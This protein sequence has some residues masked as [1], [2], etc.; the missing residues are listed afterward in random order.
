M[1]QSTE[2]RFW[3]KVN[4]TDSCWL[5]TAYRN[6]KGYG[7]FGMGGHRG[8]MY[9]AH[10][11]SWE[12]ANGTIP[13]G[14]YVCHACDV[15][16]CVNP[17]H[18]WLGTATDNNRDMFAKGRAVSYCGTKTHCTNGHPFDSENTRKRPGGKRACAVCRSEAAKRYWAKRP[19]L[20]AE[21]SRQWR[22]A[23]KEVASQSMHAHT[24]TH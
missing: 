16:A 20:R 9:L 1:R 7:E 13:D 12:M 24:L 6:R 11:V 17:S 2:Q 4:K 15:P 22:Q 3:A 21:R 23:R 18:L 14:M 19:G 5:W 8:R 10:R